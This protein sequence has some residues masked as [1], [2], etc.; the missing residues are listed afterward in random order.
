MKKVETI[1]GTKVKEI[2]TK[3]SVTNTIVGW[4]KSEL[5]ESIAPEV[6]SDQVSNMVDE[7]FDEITCDL[8]QQGEDEPCEDC[9]SEMCNG[10]CDNPDCD[11]SWEATQEGDDEEEDT[12]HLKIAKP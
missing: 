3:E 1:K 7:L 4:F 9:G 6:F 5:P 10:F 12:P 8:E 11:N 2:A